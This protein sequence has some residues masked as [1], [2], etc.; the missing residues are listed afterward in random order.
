M[1]TYYGEEKYGIKYTKQYFNTLRKLEKKDGTPYLYFLGA[2]RRSDSTKSKRIMPAEYCV[3]GIRDPD[4][5][6]GWYDVFKR[7]TFV[8][9]Y[10]N[11]AVRRI[12][13]YWKDLGEKP[14]FRMPLEGEGKPA[15]APAAANP[16]IRTTRSSNPSNEATQSLRN[17][18]DKLRDEV[19]SIKAATDRVL[20][21]EEKMAELMTKMG[22]LTTSINE[23]KQ[24]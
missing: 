18:L 23:M 2:A 7:S 22:E 5:K 13:N 10:G 3:I 15:A 16:D 6:T 19:S 21:F 11:D 14:S 24:K 9:L 17:D 20:S 12:D 8:N 1:G 4:L